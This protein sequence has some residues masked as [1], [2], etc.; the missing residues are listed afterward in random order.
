MLHQLPPHFPTFLKQ[1][2]VMGWDRGHTTLSVERASLKRLISDFL[3]IVTVDEQWYLEVYP[4]VAAEV[5][6][7]NLVSATA[8]YREFGYF[9]GRLPNRRFFDPESY[10]M[11]NPD[12]V[13][14][15]GT[16]PSGLFEHFVKHGYAEAR[17][18]Q[19]PTSNAEVETTD[20]KR[21]V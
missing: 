6:S 18:L 16:D 21:T 7:G 9:E 10:S 14:A 15:H 5:T 12:V 19:P 17:S 13:I 3:A 11:A 2:K 4:D 20:G 1:G 8:H